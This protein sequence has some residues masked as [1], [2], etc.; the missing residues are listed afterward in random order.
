MAEGR[1]PPEPCGYGEAGYGKAGIPRNPPEPRGPLSSRLVRLLQN[2][3][4]VQQASFAKL[5]QH[6]RQPAGV[7][8]IFHLHD[9]SSR[10]MRQNVAARLR[11][12]IAV[13][14]ITGLPSDITGNSSGNPPAS[15]TPRFT[16]TAISRKCALQGV[17]SDQVLQMPMTGRP[18]SRCGGRP[19]FFIHERCTMLSM[20]GSP[21]Q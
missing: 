17:S 15:S 13:G 12:S 6:H 9:A 11:N 21:N 14:R 18:S 19:W 8:E 7:I 16:R 10:H 5:A 1:Y 20:P 2:R 4:L 3:V